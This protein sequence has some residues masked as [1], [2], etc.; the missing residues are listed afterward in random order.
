MAALAE[1]SKSGTPLMHLFRAPG[2]D[3]A[4]VLAEAQKN[5]SSA[6]TGLETEY[7]FNIEVTGAPYEGKELEMLTWLVA[8]TYEPQQTQATSFITGRVSDNTVLVVEVGPRFAYP[9]AFSSNAVNICSS[10]GLG[11]VTRVE[12]SRRYKLITPQAAGLDADVVAAFLASVHDKMT[13]QVYPETLAVSCGGCP[14]MVMEDGEWG[15]WL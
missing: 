10:C 3:A 1:E 4:N 6:I 14:V 11:R 7:C 5:V 12:R 13:E 9:S 2:P 8:E 15:G